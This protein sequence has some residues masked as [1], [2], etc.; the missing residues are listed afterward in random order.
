MIHVSL[1]RLDRLV[2]P[3]WGLLSLSLLLDVGK[4]ACSHWQPLCDHEGPSLEMKSTRR[5]A[6]DKDIIESCPWRQPYL[7]TSY[8]RYII[9][10][11]IIMQPLGAGPRFQPRE[12]GSKAHSV[13][14]HILWMDGCMDG[15]TD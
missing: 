13:T 8:H 12:S 9:K 3:I 15:S 14:Y 4:E 7:W 11:P 1:T 5:M 2:F 6:M 10:L